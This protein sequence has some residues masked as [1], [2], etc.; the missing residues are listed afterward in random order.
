M[1]LLSS[2]NH[3]E[4]DERIQFSDS[5]HT[6]LIDKK[7]KAVSVT[8]LIGRYFPKFDKDFWANKE[9]IKTGKPKNEIL[10]KWDEL[11]NKARDL[12]TELHEQIENFYNSKEYIRSKEL[13]KFFKFHKNHIQDK[14]QPHRTEWRIFDENKNLAGTVDMVYEKENGELFIFDWKRSK[15]IINSDGSIEKNNPFENGINGLSHLPSSDYVKYC[16][17]QNMYK[18]ILESKYDKKVSSMNL[19]ILHPHLENYH[20]IQV[21][22][23]KNETKYLLDS[24]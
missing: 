6:Y 17:Q 5:D 13:D 21:E 15:K 3:H 1:D 14:Y 18:N 11:G 24:I 20:I 4:R 12:G 23:F 16:L 9:S 22:S 2:K 10:K 19:L 8:E 7:N